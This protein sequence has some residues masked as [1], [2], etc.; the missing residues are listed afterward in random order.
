AR[1]GIESTSS[2][3]L[4]QVLNPLSHN[5]NS[6]FSVLSISA[7]R[8]SI[9][10][11]P[12]L[13]ISFLTA[14]TTEGGEA[15]ARQPSFEAA[16][17]SAPWPSGTWHTTAPPPRCPGGRSALLREEPKRRLPAKPAPA[18]VE[19]KPKK[20]AGKDKSSDQKVKTK[21]K[22]EQKGKQAEVTNQETKEDLPAENGETK[23][24]ESP[25]SDAAGKKP[26]LID[27][28]RPVLSVVPV[29]LPVQSRIF[30]S[31]IL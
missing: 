4:G 26:R 30:L 14:P 1:P 27:T 18:K 15:R 16:L 5:G 25:G 22:G 13:K 24:E 7:I 6:L 12:G 20:V 23:N 9:I 2:W 3:T 28:T 11:K 29:S 17:N 31:T 19:T 21:G 10:Q 8:P